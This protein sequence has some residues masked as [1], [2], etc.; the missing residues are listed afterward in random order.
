MSKHRDAGMRYVT[1]RPGK[2]GPRF[3]WQRKGYPLTRLP[4]G[5]LERHRR[6]KELND[7]ADKT[8]PA[9]ASAA[10][11]DLNT[12]SGIV[13]E[14]RKHTSF[15]KLSPNSRRYYERWLEDIRETWG[16]LRI[17]IVDKGMCEDYLAS[18][19]SVGERQKARAVL[20][21]ML[22][23]AVSLRKLPFNPTNE[24]R[25]EE[26]KA[27]QEYFYEDDLTDFI[28]GCQT[29]RYGAMVFVG[30]MLLLFT[31]QRVG[32]MLRM[33][34]RQYDNGVIR[35]KQ[36]KTG[37]WVDVPAHPQLK[38]MLDR[39][40]PESSDLLI[41]MHN[42]RPVQQKL[43]NTR[44][45]EIKRAV[46]LGGKQARDLRRTAV[47]RMAEGGAEIQD[48]AA[49]T[50]HTIETTKQILEVYMPRTLKMAKRG[51]ARMGNLSL[52]FSGDWLSNAYTKSLS[53]ANLSKY[54]P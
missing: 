36:Q 13:A 31:G 33:T 26:P 39:L 18:V 8:P 23:R 17:E 22:H 54:R 9:M 45:N 21:Q 15:A 35:L 53:S 2:D 7:W 30:F 38:A 44:F 16:K 25:L 41:M 24:I 29:H 4:D 48:I 1:V 3:Y 14:Y 11:D 46:G 5:E 6:A 32:D 37:K 19:E 28:K 10:P 42:G 52:T 12:V 20:R 50:G 34:W 51:V 47:V 27:R 40:R 49:V 43:F